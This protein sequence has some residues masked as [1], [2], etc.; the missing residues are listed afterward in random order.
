MKKNE[1]I[2]MIS[3]IIFIVI[4]MVLSITVA[5]N[6]EAIRDYSHKL[7]TR[8]AQLTDELETSNI[9]HTE[10]VNL[11]IEDNNSLCLEI[12]ELREQNNQLI[13]ENEALREEIARLE[14]AAETLSSMIET[15]PINNYAIIDMTDEERDLLAR[16]LALEAHDQPDVGQRAVVEVVFNRILTGWASTVKGVLL[17]KGQFDSVKYLDKPYALPDGNEYE[18][19]DYVLSHG[20]TILPPDYVYFATYK[21]NG[22]DFLQ[23]QD[24]YFAREK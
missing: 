23:I 8:V 17:Q 9:M 19:I 20:S 7:E 13:E 11:L 1:A 5:I 16:I 12:T 2:G 24:H 4:W 6:C 10:E 3:V 22:K 18:N 14:I 15:A 21:A